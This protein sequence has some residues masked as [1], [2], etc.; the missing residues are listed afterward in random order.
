VSNVD[1]TDS[2][3]VQTKEYKSKKGRR[4]LALV[5]VVLFILLITV[6]AFLARVILPQGEIAKGEEAGGLTW[7][8]SIYG[9][10]PSEKEQILGPGSTAVGGYGTIWTNDGASGK[11]VGFTPDGALK[12]TIG[13]KGPTPVLTATDVAADADGRVYITESSQDIL[14]V[15]N[16][17]D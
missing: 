13:I 1:T 16:A 9:W 3:P 2:A 17:A 12:A 10:G 5:L 15:R 14:H 4:I 11:V 7:V 8:R 6:S